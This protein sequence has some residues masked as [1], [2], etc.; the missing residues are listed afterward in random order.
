MLNY[1]ETFVRSLLC[2]I[3][4]FFALATLSLFSVFV[5]PFPERIVVKY[6]Y[7]MSCVLHYISKYVAGIDANISGLDAVEQP[8]IF[9]SRHESMWET[10]FLVVALKNPV[11]ILKKELTDIPVFGTFLKKVGSI[12][13][14]R[15]NGGAAMRSMV[16]Q[17]IKTLQ[18]GRS[19][20]I[21][22]EGTRRAANDPVELK[23]GIAV[24]YKM[25]NAN[26]VPVALNSGTFW[27]R[28][29]FLKRQGTIDLRFLEKIP[30]GMESDEFMALLE[31]RLNESLFSS[32]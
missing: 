10:M 28:R 29:R 9:A 12:S 19:I 3:F 21:F 7:F 13:V 14:D 5:W 27:P 6:W 23:K 20:I 25:A 8:C 22:P 31:Q 32:K 1:I 2:N 4:F 11:F 18:K 24:I 16:K 17:V 26:V 15:S 30:P